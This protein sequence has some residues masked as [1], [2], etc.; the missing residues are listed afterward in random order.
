MSI[1]KLQGEQEKRDGCYYEF[2][3][4]QKPL[5]EGGYGKSLPWQTGEH[6]YR[7]YT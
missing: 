2:D 3:N 5:G 7:S 1:I 4:S 6:I